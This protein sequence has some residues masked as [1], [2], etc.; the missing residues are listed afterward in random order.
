MAI[1]IPII[2]T[3]IL[4]QIMLKYRFIKEM[5]KEAHN[6]SQHQNNAHPKNSPID[7]GAVLLTNT[8]CHM[9][10]LSILWYKESWTIQ[11]DI[12]IWNRTGNDKSIISSN[13][14]AWPHQR[15]VYLLERAF[16]ILRLQLYYFV[17]IHTCRHTKLGMSWAFDVGYW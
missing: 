8:Q 6:N 15:L 1:K 14:P 9:V 3:T 11:F 17:C 12:Y 13:T 5:T 4:M 7:C 10:P 2:V 16:Y